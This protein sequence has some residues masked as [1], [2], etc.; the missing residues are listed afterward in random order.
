[1]SEP[2]VDVFSNAIVQK[3]PLNMYMKRCPAEIG[4]RYRSEFCAL[5]IVREQTSIP[6]PRPIDLIETSTETFIITSRIPGHTVGKSIDLCSDAETDQMVD[7]LQHYIKELRT[8]PNPFAEKYAICN[9]YGEACA[10]RSGGPFATEAEFNESLRVG[11]LVQKSDHKI[12]YT[13]ADLNMR[14]TLMNN[15]RIS[16]I[17]DWEGAAWF[18]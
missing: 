3:L 2:I 11:H 6:V 15:G 9:S 10:V 16:G 18:P 12:I 14:N 7:D 17:I 1:M 13:H 4:R 8:I 5:Q